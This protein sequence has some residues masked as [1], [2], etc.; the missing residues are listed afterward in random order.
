MNEE[1]FVI[2]LLKVLKR[3]KSGDY[4]PEEE[5]FNRSKLTNKS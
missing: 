5:F 4:M 3:I 2:R 1:Q